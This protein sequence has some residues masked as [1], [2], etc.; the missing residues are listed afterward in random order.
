[1]DQR[2][3]ELLRRVGKLDLGLKPPEYRID[4]KEAVWCAIEARKLM[5]ELEP[6]T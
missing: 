1:M 5:W 6:K 3:I 2:I 4:S